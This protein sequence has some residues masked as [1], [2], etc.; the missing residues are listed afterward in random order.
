MNLKTWK[1]SSSKDQLTPTDGVEWTPLVILTTHATLKLQGITP[2]VHHI[3]VR[4]APKPET[5]ERQPEARDPFDYSCEPLPDLKLLFRK[6]SKAVSFNIRAH[7]CLQAKDLDTLIFRKTL[8]CDHYSLAN[9]GA[10][11]LK[12]PGVLCLQ[13]VRQIW[14]LRDMSS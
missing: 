12:L 2:R 8:A 11:Y 4:R 3:R 14:L 6:T 5:L 13:K 1:T 7:F 9:M 10:I